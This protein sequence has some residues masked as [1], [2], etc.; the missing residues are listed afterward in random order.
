MILKKDKNIARGGL[1]G[2]AVES[3]YIHN[4][5]YMLVQLA[6]SINDLGAMKLKDKLS[7]VPCD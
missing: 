7:L 1:G 3:D 5:L 6:F 2:T 4:E